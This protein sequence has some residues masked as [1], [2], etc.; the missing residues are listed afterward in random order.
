MIIQVKKLHEDAVVPTRA[1]KLDSGLDLYSYLL[2]DE[3]IINEIKLLP[4]QRAVIPCGISIQLP[5]PQKLGDLQIVFEGQIRPKSGL[6][7]NYGLAIVNSPGTIDY[8]FTGELKVIALNT[9][10]DQLIVIKHK[11]KI[12]QLVVCPIVLPQVFVVDELDKSER[13]DKGWGS[14]G[15]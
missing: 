11:Q 2:C 15:L 12:A 10:T 14:S 3:E 7:L 13:D 9:S 6:A 4:G 5:P 1:Y 8:G